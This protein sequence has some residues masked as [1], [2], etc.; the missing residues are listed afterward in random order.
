MPAKKS[1]RVKTS[2][3]VDPEQLALAQDLAGPMKMSE[4]NCQA[5]VLRIALA[6][7]LRKLKWE[8]ESPEYRASATEAFL[9]RGRVSLARWRK[10][11]TSLA[12]ARGLPVPDFS[13]FD[14]TEIGA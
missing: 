4:A 13:G 7:G 5:D 2:I 6:H 1:P 12:L 9:D 11:Q 14:D 3:L 10:K 8:N